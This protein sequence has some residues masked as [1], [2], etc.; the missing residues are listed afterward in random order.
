MLAKKYCNHLFDE[1]TDGH[2]QVL[3]IDENKKIK[4]YNTENN[5][6]REIV[7]I[8][9]GK[10]D[11]YMNV[12]TTYKPFRVVENIRQFR[13]LYIDLDLKQ[14]DFKTSSVY[15]VFW[16]AYEGKIPRPTMVVDSGRGIHLYW[17]VQNAPYGALN[18]WQQLEDYLYY[19]L[20]HLGA[21][22]RA[23]DGARVLRLPGTINSRNKKRCEVIYV[24][25]KTTYTMYDLR[26]Q[27]LDYKN[28]K[29]KGKQ[30]E[31]TQVKKAKS[32]VIN[33][34]FFNSYSLHM[35][36]AADLITL[37]ELRK[38]NVTGYR[39]MIIHCYAYWRGLIVRDEEQ[40]Y[41]EV[42]NLNNSFT[43]P[44]KENEIKSVCKTI[45]KKVDLFITYE[46]ELRIGLKPKLPR[47]TKD[48]PGYWYKNQTLIER[49]DIT[50]EEQRNLKT[51][52]G[53]K[54]KYEKNNLRR[55][56][57]NEKGLTKKQQ[58]LQELKVKVLELKDQNLSNRA[59]AKL[60]N[61]SE[62]TI[63]NILKR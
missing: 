17:R 20:K 28:Y 48:K 7:E 50:E 25:N 60:L 62:G 30:L 26:E 8:Q 55:T 33:N 3:E 10:E 15:E 21:D 38:Y 41:K 57:R 1:S 22:L 6:L 5:H 14:G 11:I 12:N 61:K 58:E 16:L 27:Y 59:I 24:D 47:G 37:V 18:T 39:N 44:L 29:E 45:L 42:L 43:E 63:R 32:K 23:I 31:F 52:I 2:L 36:R 40:L 53:K 4:I 46:N 54:I 35:E 9:Q 13:A 49:L 19:N 34:A 51:I 56:P